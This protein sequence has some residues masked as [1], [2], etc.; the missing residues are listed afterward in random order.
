MTKPTSMA[1][2]VVEVIP[3]CSRADTARLAHLPFRE[4]VEFSVLTIRL[5]T[6]LAIAGQPTLSTAGLMELIY[7]EILLTMEAIASGLLTSYYLT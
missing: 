6:G 1:H 4:C 7:R 3:I 2:V 5:C